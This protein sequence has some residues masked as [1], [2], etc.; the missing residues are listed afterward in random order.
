[1]FWKS[2]WTP[3]NCANSLGSLMTMKHPLGTVSCKPNMFSFP[4]YPPLL[5]HLNFT[6]TIHSFSSSIFAILSLFLPF[7]CNLFSLFLI[8]FL[9]WQWLPLLLVAPKTFCIYPPLQSTPRTHFLKLCL[10]LM[11]TYIHT[12]THAHTQT[13]NK[14]K[15]FRR[16]NMEFKPIK[17]F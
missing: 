5:F 9:L 2:P 12:H 15:K 17:Y 16:S 11:Q 3:P 7:S 8:P 10:W 14:I 1:M 4:R 13:Q 6:S